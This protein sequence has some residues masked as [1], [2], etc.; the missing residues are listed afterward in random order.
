MNIACVKPADQDCAASARPHC[1][2]LRPRLAVPRVLSFC[3]IR[4]GQ[5]DVP[6]CGNLISRA[7]RHLSNLSL[8]ATLEISPSQK[9]NILRSIDYARLSDAG[10]SKFKD[11]PKLSE[12]DTVE[13]DWS[14]FAIF[15]TRALSRNGDCDF[16]EEFGYVC[17][18]R[19]V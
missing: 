17:V 18:Q 2:T 11:I 1:I 16:P 3:W 13:A 10:Q 7:A 5:K 4:Y 12:F 8:P 19:V 6:P 9:D 14:P 15:N